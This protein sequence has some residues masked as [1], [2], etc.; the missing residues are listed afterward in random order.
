M[1]IGILT[2]HRACNYGAVLQ[3][4]ALQ[5]VLK[6]IGHDVSVIDYADYHTSEVY[7]VIS[8]Y[9]IRNEILCPKSF[10]RYLIK[11]PFRIKSKRIFEDF[12]SH[13]LNITQRCNCNTIPQD[14]D[15]YIIGSDQL[16]S[17]SCLGGR[18]NPVYMGDFKHSPFSKIIGYAISTTPKSLETIGTLKLERYSN[19]FSSLSFREESNVNIL[20]QLIGINAHIDIDPTLLSN[21]KTWKALI[22]DNWGKRKYVFTYQARGSKGDLMRRKAKY[23]AKKEGWEY[24]DMSASIFSVADFISAIKYAQ[25]IITSSFHAT[26]FSLIFKKPFWAIMLNDGHDARYIDLL[27][28]IGADEAIKDLNFPIE[29]PKRLDYTMIESRLRPIRENSLDYLQKNASINV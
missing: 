23:L 5:E 2:F 16:W 21:N 3:C 8:F 24:L 14:F 22:N 4:Y 6:S 11:I 10:L 12:V 28:K 19:N 27:H 1:K 29:Q 26:V 18:E 7:K 17:L 20:S 25:C 15:I 13:Y 9:V